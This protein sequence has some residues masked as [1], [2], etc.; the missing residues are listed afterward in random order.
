V[1]LGVKIAPDITPSSSTPAAVFSTGGLHQNG[2][3]HTE[4]RGCYKIDY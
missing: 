1:S 2:M 3:L 4:P